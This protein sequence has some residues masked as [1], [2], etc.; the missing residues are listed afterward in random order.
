MITFLRLIFDFGRQGF[1]TENFSKI[2]CLQFSDFCILIL[3][4][5]FFKAVFI[6][7]IA[8]TSFNF[9]WKTSSTSPCTSMQVYIGQSPAWSTSSTARHMELNKLYFLN[10]HFLTSPTESK[11]PPEL[12]KMVILSQEDS[13]LTS[14]AFHLSHLLY[15]CY[16]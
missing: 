14:D 8:K 16:M 11:I 3:N 1:N 5:G 15:C 9:P 13:F 4:L 6:S 10:S 2:V 12:R 7:Y